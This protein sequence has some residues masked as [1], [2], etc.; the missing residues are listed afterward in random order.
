MGNDRKER[1][2]VAVS[3][4]NGAERDY[5]GEILLPDT[6]AEVEQAYRSLAE[7]ARTQEFGLIEDDVVVFD[8][9]TTGL[10][11][12]ECQLTEIAAVRLRGREVV[13]TFRTFVN[14]GMPIPKN[15]QAL[16]NITDLDVAAAPSPR[17][18]VAQ[19]ADFVAGAP[20]LAHNAT[21][22]RT[23]IERV[24]GG[25]EVSDLWVDTLA[26]SRIALPRL[27]THKL[28]DMAEAFG[29]G[30]RT[31]P[32]RHVARHPLCPERPACRAARDACEHASGC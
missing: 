20:V 32:G 6:T 4:D 3:E 28:Q 31:C 2:S 22:D 13:D 1:E 30:R 23:F 18:A 26:L 12:S 21:F 10:S 7:R 15:I 11:F 8:T 29:P 9:E 17:E 19:L 25:H 14:P 24:P 16:T 5:L 27:S